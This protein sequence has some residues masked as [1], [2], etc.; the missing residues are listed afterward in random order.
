MRHRAGQLNMSH[1]L[2]AHFGQRH[3]HAT[4]FANHTAM[5]ETLVLAAEAFVILDGTEDLGAEQA[6]TLGFECAIVNGLRFFDFTVGPG[7]N[8]GWRGKPD[9]NGIEVQYLALLT[10]NF[11]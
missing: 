4:F 9:A 6:I 5:F 7:A 3:F 8:L 11:E 1:T 10:Q 2:T